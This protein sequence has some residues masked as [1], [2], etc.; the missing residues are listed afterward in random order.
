MIADRM[1]VVVIGKAMEIEARSTVSAVLERL[2]LGRAPCAV[3][4][5]RVL[6]PRREHHHHALCDRDQVEIVTLVGGG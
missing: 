5:N 2:G 6:V 4:V 3:E 1:N